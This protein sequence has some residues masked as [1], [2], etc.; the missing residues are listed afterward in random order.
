MKRLVVLVSIVAI[1][2]GLLLLGLTDS[3]TSNADTN[4]PD[5]GVASSVS[6]TAILIQ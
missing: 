4:I 3:S 5:D 1:L 2:T 6:E